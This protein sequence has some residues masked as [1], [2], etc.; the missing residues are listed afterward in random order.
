M[1]LQSSNSPVVK[2]VTMVPTEA[3]PTVPEAAIPYVYPFS[4]A[5]C[6]LS[7]TDLLNDL[8]AHVAVNEPD[9]KD[10]IVASLTTEN[11]G[12]EQL[13]SFCLT[14]PNLRTIILCGTDPQQAIGH[15][16]GQTLMALVEHGVALDPKD[17]TGTQFRI[18]NAQGKRP[19]LTNVPIEAIEHFRQQIRLVNCIDCHDVAT[20]MSEVHQA[21]DG[22]PGPVEAFELV[23][24]VEVTQGF[25]P[26]N[27]VCDPGGYCVIQVD[28]S[29]RLIHLKHYTNQGKLIAHI[30]GPTAKHI[31]FPLN[32][33][34]LI[35]QMDHAAY[36]G[37]ELFRAE[38]ALLLG[39]TYIQDEIS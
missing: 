30:Q 9:L 16:P 20:I 26:K 36:L 21:I 18:T 13:L 39:K 17:P 12:I 15:L 19:I 37:R 28:T 5:V 3:Q 10:M 8:M 32:E 6:T 7:S 22:N 33:S 24:S 25:V 38:R 35:T 27:F 14:A 4:V 29:T 23:S 34:G 1:V 31:I 11:I 2:T